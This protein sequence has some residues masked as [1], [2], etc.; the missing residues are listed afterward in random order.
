MQPQCDT[1]NITNIL[2]YLPLSDSVN[3]RNAEPDAECVEVTTLDLD[4]ATT[5]CTKPSQRDTCERLEHD[6]TLL[7]R[8]TFIFISASPFFRLVQSV[9]EERFSLVCSLTSLL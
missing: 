7:T 9:D 6:S 4:T 1:R 8:T 3:T 2:C 5:V